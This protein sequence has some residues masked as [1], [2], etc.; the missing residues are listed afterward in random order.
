MLNDRD[1]FTDLTAKTSWL[2]PETNTIFGYGID[3]FNILEDNAITQL[4]VVDN[5]VYKGSTTFTWYFKRGNSI[6]AKKKYNEMS[7]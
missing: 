5:E 1:T 3:A 4:V 2:K 7:F 6:M